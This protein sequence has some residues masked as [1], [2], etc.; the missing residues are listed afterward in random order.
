MGGEGNR[1]RKRREEGG[2]GWNRREEGRKRREMGKGGRKEWRKMEVYGGRR[3]MEGAVERTRMRKEGENR[4]G[5][6]QERTGAV[7]MRLTRGGRSDKGRN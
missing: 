6:G 7:R 5:M 4:M 1:G 2:R 3:G